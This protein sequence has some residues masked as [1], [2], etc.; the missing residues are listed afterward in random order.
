MRLDRFW[1]LHKNVDRLAAEDNYRFLRVT[2]AAAGGGEAI[3]ETIKALQKEM[4]DV[5]VFDEGK[6]ALRQA[7]GERDPAG[8]MQLKALENSV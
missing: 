1:L 4:G 2:A 8:L 7:E 6:R 5:A 3:T